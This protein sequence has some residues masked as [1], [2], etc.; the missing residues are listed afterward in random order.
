LRERAVALIQIAHPRFRE[1]LQAAAKLNK[2]LFVD[3]IIPERAIYPVE[4][5]TVKEINGL[6]LFVRPVKA[7][8]ERLFQEYLYKLSERS[9]YLRFFAVRKDFPHEIAQEM[10]A[11]DYESN[12]GIVCTLDISDTSPIIAAGH[13]MLDYND[14]MA[15][16]AFSVADEYQHQ[17]IGT[18]LLHFLIRVARERGIRGFR[19]DVIAG[20]A[21]MMNVFQKSN[22]VIHTEYDG[23]EISLWFQFDEQVK[24]SKNAS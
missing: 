5:E 13:W 24:T 14:N 4:L 2:I 12:M 7:S 23:G 16:V 15:E 3:Q 1:E 9:V 20:N 10:V 21:S 22:C 8:D 19:A 18:Y 6:E 17:G 11:I